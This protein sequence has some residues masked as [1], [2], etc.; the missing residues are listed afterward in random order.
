MLTL[1]KL[2]P[3]FVLVSIFT[4]TGKNMENAKFYSCH[5]TGEEGK[6]SNEDTCSSENCLRR[7]FICVVEIS[8]DF[9]FVVH[10]M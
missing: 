1:G 8:P 7:H 10:K 3:L 4:K 2:P 6:P 5:R 9:L